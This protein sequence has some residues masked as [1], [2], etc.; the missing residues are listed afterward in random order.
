MTQ[1]KAV[2]ASVSAGLHCSFCAKPHTEVK[3]LIAG[4]MVYIC[5]QC[6][7]LC[8]DIIEEEVGKPLRP[9]IP[10]VPSTEEER[11]FW[12]AAALR[13]GVTEADTLLHIYRQRF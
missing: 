9:D 11:A 2:E 10:K 7:G 3:K 5:D 6:I 8:N 13:G 12:R 1:P 4:P